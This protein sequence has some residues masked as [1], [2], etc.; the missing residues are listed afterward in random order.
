M[1]C[2]DSDPFQPAMGGC[3]WVVM[4]DSFSRLI[5]ASLLLMNSNLAVW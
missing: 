2:R 5:S 4:G 1:W 3:M